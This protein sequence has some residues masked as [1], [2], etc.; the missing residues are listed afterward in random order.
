M[1]K[2]VNLSFLARP[3]GSDLEEAVLN[4]TKLDM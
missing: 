2:N 3:E 4:L 1:A